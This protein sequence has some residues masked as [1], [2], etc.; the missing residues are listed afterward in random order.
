MYINT[1]D[2]VPFKCSVSLLDSKENYAGENC[3]L[4]QVEVEKYYSVYYDDDKWYIGRI[5]DFED[6]T[7]TCKNKFLQ[8][9]DYGFRWPSLEDVQMV[10]RKFILSG[11]IELSGNLPFHIKYERRKEIIYLV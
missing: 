1:G 10:E 4:P 9:T 5:P 6:T 7:R 8:E 3:L 11:P 2:N